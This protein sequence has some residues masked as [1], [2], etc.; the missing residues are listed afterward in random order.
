MT[1][2]QGQGR[3]HRLGHLARVDQIAGR[4]APG[5]VRAVGDKQHPQKLR[6]VAQGCQHHPAQTHV[7][8]LVQTLVG[9]QAR[10]QA[11]Q[12]AQIPDVANAGGCRR[13]RGP[14]H[15]VV[16]LARQAQLAH[17]IDDPG[18]GVQL[19]L[20]VRNED[21]S[22][23]GA[24]KPRDTLHAIEQ[25]AVER[26]QAREVGADLGQLRALVLLGGFA[27]HL[28]QPSRSIHVRNSFG[29]QSVGRTR[30]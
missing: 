21:R 22:P 8:P 30:K 2:V 27:S 28:A 10:V 6:V 9:A 15:E 24:E 20:P 11:H 12:L 14:A 1:E 16:R 13:G 19:V 23:L 17:G 7:Q 29:F 26:R 25:Q 5:L 4:E 18:H 3:S